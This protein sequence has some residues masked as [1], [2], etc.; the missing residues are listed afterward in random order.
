MQR[1]FKFAFR[2]LLLLVLMGG[3]ASMFPVAAEFFNP[4]PYWVLCPLR[5]C[6]AIFLVFIFMGYLIDSGILQRLFGKK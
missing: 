3:I 1:F 2:L 4:L 6:A 5:I